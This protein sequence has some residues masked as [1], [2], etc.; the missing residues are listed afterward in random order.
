[1]DCISSVGFI[2][3][4]KTFLFLPHD[5]TLKIIKK[6]LTNQSHDKKPM[7]CV[8]IIFML[9]TNFIIFGTITRL[10]LNMLNVKRKQTLGKCGK[11]IIENISARARKT[12]GRDRGEPGPSL[13]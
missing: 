7:C 12:R 8:G 6:N 3:V 11:P 2:T 10:L 4:K 1:M 5:L 9:G 13:L